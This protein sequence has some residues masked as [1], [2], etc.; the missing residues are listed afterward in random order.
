MS[1]C[2]LLISLMQLINRAKFLNAISLSLLSIDLAATNCASVLP[3]GGPASPVI[4][5]SP[6]TSIYALL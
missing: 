5:I 2:V 4:T 3:A 6:L 1:I